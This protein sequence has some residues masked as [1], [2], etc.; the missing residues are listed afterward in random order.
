[1]HRG[2][3]G[4]GTSLDSSR[5]TGKKKIYT[6][7]FVPM[8]VTESREQRWRNLHARSSQ[9]SKWKRWVSVRAVREC[10]KERERASERERARETY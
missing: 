5:A 9:P 3:R 2:G 6:R 4:D 8:T 1:M 10:V 7:I